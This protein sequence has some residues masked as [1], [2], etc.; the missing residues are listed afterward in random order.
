MK[1]ILKLKRFITPYIWQS[2]LAL[3]MLTSVV[4]MDLSIPRLIQRIIDQGITSGNLNVVLNTTL[5]MLGLTVLSA[6][7][8]SATISSPYGL[9]KAT[10]GTCARRCSSKS[11]LFPLA[12][13]IGCRPGN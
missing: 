10:G 5:I 8:P 12:I 13:W 3:V 1:D 9:A 4:F 11:N 2:I 7:S 6:C